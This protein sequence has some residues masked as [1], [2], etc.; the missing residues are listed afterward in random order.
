[1]YDE[2]CETRR[3]VA[4]LQARLDDQQKELDAMRTHVHSTLTKQQVLNARADEVDIK[5]SEAA[6][7]M[8]QRFEQMA[9]NI[10]HATIWQREFDHETTL[11]RCYYTNPLKFIIF[12]GLK[13]SVEAS[14]ESHFNGG[15][16]KFPANVSAPLLEMSFNHVFQPTPLESQ[17]NGGAV[18]F[19]ANVA[20]PVLEKSFNVIFKLKTLVTVYVDHSFDVPEF[21]LL[22]KHENLTLH[23]QAGS[24]HYKYVH[25]LDPGE[26]TFQATTEGLTRTKYGDHNGQSV[27]RIG[28]VKLTYEFKPFTVDVFPSL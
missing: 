4:A 24:V 13:L 7:D 17:F 14:N 21:A 9:L 23:N 11:F 6:F 5:A 22:W 19:P 8:R 20:A 25:V 18:K 1:M 3:L 12:K 2:L 15:G 16:V 27:R 10:D 28:P 26:Y